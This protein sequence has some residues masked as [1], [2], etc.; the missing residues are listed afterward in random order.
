MAALLPDPIRTQRRV[1][2]GAAA[3]LALEPR[4]SATRL[5]A[6]AA[7]APYAAGL[8]RPVRVSR[9]A[10]DLAALDAFYGPAGMRTETTLAIA[11]DEASASA[12]ASASAAASAAAA[13]AASAASAVGVR[14]YL[15]PVT[16]AVF[17]R[18][19]SLGGV[20]PTVGS[21]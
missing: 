20:M 2:A 1:D 4:L 21:R 14:C 15:W 3:L 5:A 6:I 17:T 13:S 10:T 12:S 18:P 9:A 7:A 16:R 11:D 19:C 8:L